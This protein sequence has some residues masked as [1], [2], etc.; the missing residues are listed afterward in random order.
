ML[1][2]INFDLVYDKVGDVESMVVD[3]LVMVKMFE[4]DDSTILNYMIKD[5]IDEIVGC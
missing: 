5:I 4:E 2:F 1:C 3:D